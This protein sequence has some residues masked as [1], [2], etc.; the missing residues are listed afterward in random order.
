MIKDF[1][2]S[3]IMKILASSAKTMDQVI[4]YHLF[5]IISRYFGLKKAAVENE[6]SFHIVL[7]SP[8]TICFDIS[9]QD[10]GFILS[11]AG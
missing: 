5:V 1:G 9:D 7:F 6:S 4:N 11:F 2:F 8:N 10:N 3:W